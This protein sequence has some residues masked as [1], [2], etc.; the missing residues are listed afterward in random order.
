MAWN[1]SGDASGAP[2][3]SSASLRAGS[4]MY[5]LQA[6]QD[7]RHV[8]RVVAVVEDRVEVQVERRFALQ[9]VAQRRLRVPCLLREALDDAVG[10]VALPA[11]VDEREQHALREERAARELEVRAHP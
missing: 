6:R 11:G 4:L 5:L 8:A 7:V 3:S 10:V 9:Q 2:Y 1:R